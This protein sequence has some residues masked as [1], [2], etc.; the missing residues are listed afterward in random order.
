[1]QFDLSNF[2]GLTEKQREAVKVIS[3]VYNEYIIQKH[4]SMIILT[5]HSMILVKPL[6]LLLLI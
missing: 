1:M 4:Q 2:F 6:S 5:V 3:S